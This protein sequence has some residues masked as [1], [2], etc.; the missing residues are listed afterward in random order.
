M[1]LYLVVKLGMI[2][3]G[4][5][6]N[7]LLFGRGEL[8]MVDEEGWCLG[9]LVGIEGVLDR[10]ILLPGSIQNS[11][12]GMTCGTPRAAFRGGILMRADP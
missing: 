3:G 2:G 8:V 1:I 12:D 10:A 6:G 11:A 4:G 7:G 9:S 5:L